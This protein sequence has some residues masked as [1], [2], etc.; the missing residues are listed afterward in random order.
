MARRGKRR[1]LVATHRGRVRAA[2]HGCAHTFHQRRFPGLVLDV[3]ALLD[4]RMADVLA[5]LHQGIG[6]AAHLAF[7]ERLQSRVTR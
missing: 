2:D 1:G 5:A 6:S 3:S 4:R 7:V